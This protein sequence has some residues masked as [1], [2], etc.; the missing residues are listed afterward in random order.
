MIQRKDGCMLQRHMPKLDPR[1]QHY[2]IASPRAGLQLFLRHLPPAAAS[3]RVVRSV[4]GG[5]FPSALSIAHR[6]DGVSWRDV[7][8]QAGFHVWGFDFL[9]FGGSDR[10]PEMK[11]PA[12]AHAPLCDAADASEQLEAAVRFILERHRL[13]QLSLI[14]HSWASMPAGRLAR[15]PAARVG[16][17]GAFA[18]VRPAATA[19][20]REAAERAGVAGRHAGGPMGAFR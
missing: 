2:W 16:P 5:T 6:F 15:R 8:C 9:G 13:P 1:E 14:T 19:P 3:E 10:Y 11:A 7:L 4:P 20:L 18:A 12:D 17:V